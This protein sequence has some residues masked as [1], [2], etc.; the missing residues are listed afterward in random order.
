A[1]L[2]QAVAGLAFGLSQYVVARAGFFS[3]NTT[4]AWVPWLA[5]AS[6]SLLAA[7]N[8]AERGRGLLWL[9]G[10]AALQLLA[11]H[12]QTTW[13][14]W[15]LLAAW[16]G[17]R[18]VAAPAGTRRTMLLNVSVL[19]LAGVWAAAIAAAQLLPTAE[20]LRQSQR[21]DSAEIGFVLTYSFSPWRLFTLL[22]P[23][24][25]GTPAGRE[26][27]G[28][29][30]YLE[31]A[32]YSGVIPLVLAVA[33]LG[34]GSARAIGA[35]VRRTAAPVRTAA[36]TGLAALLIA[37]GLILGLGANTPVFP[38]L[39]AHVPTFN[40]FQ[41][42]TRMMLW[43]VFGLALLAG[44]GVTR[45]QA[46]GGRALY[47]T[48]L[49]TA[50]AAGLALVAFGLAAALDPTARP[51]ALMRWMALGAAPAGINLAV[52][53]AL[54]LL[55]PG[56]HGDA[57]QPAFWR[58]RRAWAW[59]TL[60][61]V[62][63]AADLIT[64]DLGVNP[65]AAAD[66]YKRPGAADAA[67]QAAAGDGRVFAFPDDEHTLKFEPYFSFASYGDPER[68]AQGAR[69]ALLPNS[70]MLAGIASFNNFDPLVSSRWLAYTAVLSETRSLALLNLADVRVLS[71]PAA[72]PQ[73]LDW[74]SWPVVAEVDGVQ[75]RA[76]PGE[77]A[78][79][80]VVYSSITV[81]DA[82][83]AAS[84][85][86][87]TDFD[88]DT[89]VIVEPALPVGSQTF[90]ERPDG[91]DQITASVSLERDGW[92]LLS[93]AAYPG[94]IAF[95]DGRPAAVHPADLAFRAVPVPAGDHTVVW[96][97][98]PEPWQWGGIISLSSLM[99]WGLACAMTAARSFLQRTRTQSTAT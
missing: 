94:W 43:L 7:S 19:G 29:G 47:W 1:P 31:D 42:P 11:G 90:T 10:L 64:A 95:V 87:A 16:V 15:L 4:V 23:D 85:L 36:P 21:A 13:Y 62:A 96:V 48:R 28:Y 12:A 66:L 86:R 63:V 46:V 84:E 54:T 24:L 76:V 14:A 49:G 18:W 32:I 3:I 70:G 5:L 74:S 51:L 30:M 91:P 98:R 69:D 40:M 37:A 44:W 27:F 57:T 20:L 81:V 99:F 72:G 2:G 73:G 88:P 58:R 26:Y 9:T 71:A 50:G 82:N 68:M 39:Y 56:A 25:L 79:T 33:T 97:Y 60:V 8:W 78:H 34:V 89:V 55:A 38:W 83:A 93:D 22:A 92:V 52:A 35:L 41:A 77:P 17:W 67:V 6:D 45:W 59:P 53:G 75:F 80:R 65:G 61:V